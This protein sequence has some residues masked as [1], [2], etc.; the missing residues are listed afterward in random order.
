ML[1]RYARSA[2]IAVFGA[3]MTVAK[4]VTE[5]TRICEEGLGPNYTKKMG[6]I[7]HTGGR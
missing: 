2:A 3:R 7:G 4:L 6:A 1:H 5:M